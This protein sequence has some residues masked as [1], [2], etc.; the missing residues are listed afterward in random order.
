[1][2]LFTLMFL[3]MFTLKLSGVITISWFWVTMPLWIIV[4]IW[5]VLI[6]VGGALASSMRGNKW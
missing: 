1:M 6:L 3:I 4:P 2:K 5:L